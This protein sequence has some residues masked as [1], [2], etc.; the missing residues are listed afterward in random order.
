MAQLIDA[1]VFI[2]L[3][4]RGQDPL[5]PLTTASDDRV[6][7]AAITASELLVG[8]HCADSPQ[9]RLRREAFVE[10]I[11]EGIPVLPFDLRVAR[12]HAQILA[13]LAAT[14]QL[15]GANDLLIAATALSYGY[16]VL[17]DN[18]RELQRVPGLV[19]RQPTW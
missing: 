1:S 3:E 11:L 15:I 16:S 14:G 17:T 6:G 10:A 12:S 5:A 4:R 19:V 7:I 2:T 8:V 18:L 9:R 13:Q